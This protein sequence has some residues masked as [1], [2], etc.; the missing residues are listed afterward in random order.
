MRAMRALL[1]I[2]ILSLPTLLFAQG[3]EPARQEF[4][5]GK[6]DPGAPVPD[7]A[8]A[9]KRMKEVAPGEFE[10]GLV[11][12]SAKTRE[13]RMPATVNMN[14]GLIE[15]LIVNET[16]KTHEALIKGTASP[17]DVQVAL[18]LTH[19]EPGHNGLFDHVKDTEIKKRREST[20]TTKP[21]A[22]KVKI[23][24][25]WKDGETTKRVLATDWLLKE[26]E[27][28]PVQDI[29]HFIFNGSMIQASGFSAELY[30]CY[31]G[32]YYDVTAIMNCPTSAMDMDDVWSPH[33]KV[34]PKPETP[35]TVIFSPAP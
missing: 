16:G 17:L 8:A 12:F 18:L 34:M 23:E 13:V 14:E 19:Y 31:V 29:P 10:L 25:E 26:P 21:G 33:T 20:K 3:E 2:T 7:P 5:Q 32:L 9:M 6:A 4:Q 27:K 28:K 22:N 35:I 15:Y 24:F 30:G 1:P 11:R